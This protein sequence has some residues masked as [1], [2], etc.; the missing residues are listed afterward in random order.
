MAISYVF[1]LQGTTIYR[2]K[3]KQVLNITSTKQICAYSKRQLLVS[4][5][6]QFAGSPVS[7]TRSGSGERASER[8]SVISNQNASSIKRQLFFHYQQTN[9]V[10]FSLSFQNRSSSP[11]TEGFARKR[12][13]SFSQGSTCDGLSQVI[14]RRPS[15]LH[16]SVCRI[17]NN[18]CR[19]YPNRYDDVKLGKIIK[20]LNNKSVM[21][22]EG[23]LLL[24]VLST[25]YEWC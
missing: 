23:S 18:N 19:T 5:T 21:P 13:Y 16:Q 17:E 9:A 14:S 20:S 22:N 2:T 10:I 6:H 1:W 7:S 4:V 12:L 15:A 8:A 25:Q 3:Q 11:V 24:D